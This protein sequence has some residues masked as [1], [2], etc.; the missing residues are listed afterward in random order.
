MAVMPDL[1]FNE[2]K[3][4]ILYGFILQMCHKIN[5]FKPDYVI[6]CNDKPPYLRKK[7]YPQY[8]EAR[9]AYADRDKD[10][11]IL[12][13]QGRVLCLEFL[14]SLNIQVLEKQGYEADDMIAVICEDLYKTVDQ[15]VVVSNDDDLFQLFQYSEN[16]YIQRNKTFYSVRNF[17][18]DYEGLE[19][20]QWPLF[21]A[22][23]GSHN[24]VPGLKGVGEKTALKI[25]RDESVLEQVLKVHREKLQL[26]QQL[27]TLPYQSDDYDSVKL[28]PAKYNNKTVRF[29]GKYDIELNGIMHK[30][31]TQINR[32]S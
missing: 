11:L 12:A 24:G 14:D 26:F 8:K 30:A 9:K 18:E 10:R 17:Y 25:I 32:N 28:I 27:A 6:V 23:K 1:E 22:L 3:T 29:F 4:G 31:F 20:S 15:I 7:I 2:Q 19:P 21:L 16:I 13:N 5:T